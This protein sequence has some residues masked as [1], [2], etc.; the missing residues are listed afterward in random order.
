[1]LV[2]G[3]GN[4]SHFYAIC[5]L[6]SFAA[7]MCVDMGWSSDR[8]AVGLA[9]GWLATSVF[10]G[11]LFTAGLWGKFADTYGRRPAFILT[12]TSIAVGNLAFGLST[13]FPAA[14]AARFLFLGAGNGTLT[15]LGTLSHELAGPDAQ[16][17]VLACMLG[18]A[19]VGQLIGP[20]VGGYL[21]GAGVPQ[22]PA[23]MSSLVGC[24]LALATTALGYCWLP[25]T[26]GGGGGGQGGGKGGGKVGGKGRGEAR[27]E[28]GGFS[29]VS[30][31]E[32]Q[33]P[34]A[35]G[36]RN[37]ASRIMVAPVDS[38]VLAMACGGGD[39]DGASEGTA[40]ARTDPACIRGAESPP[41]GQSLDPTCA[42]A[43]QQ[44]LLHAPPGESE[45]AA[46]VEVEARSTATDASPPSSGDVATPPGHRSSRR[47]EP[48]RTSSLRHLLTREPALRRVCLLRAAVGFHFF[49]AVELVPLWA[50]APAREGGLGL[51]AARVGRLCLV[52][53]CGSVAFTWL[54]MAPAVDA[55]GLRASVSLGSAVGAASLVALTCVRETT[56]AAGG[57][58]GQ[59]AAFWCT[60][61]LFSL[62]SMGCQGASSAAFALT[63]NAVARPEDKGLANGIAVTVS[64]AR[65]YLWFKVAMSPCKHSTWH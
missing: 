64:E 46:R 63:N 21:Y 56:A 7:I 54:G 4:L 38:S 61:V 9:A 43:P 12:Q 47:R 11:R 15:L 50:V 30:S 59:A 65:G 45:E 25:E 35:A 22:H 17:Q 60:A 34:M 51:D 5:S 37:D 29:V 62:S 23:L 16:T 24:G 53:G 26:G 14:V 10:A 39:G 27:H 1:V 3:L 20:A 49:A 6:F 44:A 40:A 8:A 2:V 41:N 18:A 31:D 28:K 36:V 42:A 19:G 32:V 58:S 33:S 55:L 48:S 57:S 13:S 52:S